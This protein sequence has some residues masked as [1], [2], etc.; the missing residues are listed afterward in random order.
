MARLDDTVLDRVRASNPATPAEFTGRGDFDA[1][2]ARLVPAP[3]PRRRRRRLLAIPAVGV[4]AVIAAVTVLPASAPQASEIIGRASA[5]IDA[6][7]GEILYA[8]TTSSSRSTDGSLQDYGTLRTWVRRAPGDP[9]PAMRTLQVSGTGDGPA[10]TEEVS[11]PGP[12]H[13]VLERYSPATGQT[14]SET[15]AQAVPGEI[16]RAGALLRTAQAGG[17]VKLAGETTLNGRPAYVLRW[18]ERSGPPYWPAIELTLWVDR[19]TYAPLQFTDHSSGRDVTGAPFDQ[20]LTQTVQAF[21]R[22]PDTAGN[23]A[24]LQMSPHGG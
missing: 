24:L 15:G 16:F 23:R 18:N 9:G 6:G 22:L 21:E 7:T 12:G 20:T 17:G 4:A 11:R 5:A 13:G 1:L 19:E 14:R 2:V 10:G 8:Q 3:A